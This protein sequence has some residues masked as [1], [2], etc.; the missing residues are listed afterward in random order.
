M[1][2]LTSSLYTHFY[3]G[4]PV[5]KAI[6][7]EQTDLFVSIFT[8]AIFVIPVVTSMLFNFPKR[9]TIEP[10]VAETAEDVLKQS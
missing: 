10:E 7:G 8:V 2:K 3:P 9:H 5:A 1:Y 4:T 6:E